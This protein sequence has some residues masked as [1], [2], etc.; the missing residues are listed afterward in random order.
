[1]DRSNRVRAPFIGLAAGLLTVF[2]SCSRG[3]AMNTATN[4]PFG[5]EGLTADD[6]SFS[7]SRFAEVRGAMFAHPYQKVWGA[8][9]QGAFEPF[10]VTRGRVLRGGVAF[11]GSWRLLG[12]ATRT[13]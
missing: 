3:G 7:G 9:G 12:A 6:R 1:M 5:I 13:G 8:A 11:G 4:E 2:A 10:P